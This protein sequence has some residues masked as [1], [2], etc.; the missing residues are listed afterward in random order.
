MSACC[1]YWELYLLILTVHDSFEK[2]RAGFMHVFSYVGGLACTYTRTKT[3]FMYVFIP[4]HCF[5]GET[6]ISSSLVD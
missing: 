1:I 5:Y 2:L 4:S 3:G 6:L